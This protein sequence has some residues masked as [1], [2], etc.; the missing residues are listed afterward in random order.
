MENSYRVLLVGGEYS[1][2]GAVIDSLRQEGT[3]ILALGW[4][5]PAEV[6]RQASDGPN[7]VIVD[8]AQD[9]LRGLETISACR[10]QA[11]EA[12]LVVVA[13]DLSVE[14]ERTVRAS[15]V[16]YL[17]VH[18]IAL[19]EIR[20]ILANAFECL[21]RR[22]PSASVVKTPQKVLV[23]DDDP[24]FTAA[25]TALLEAEGYVVVTAASGS[26]GLAKVA[27][28]RPSLVILDIMMEDQWAGYA[29]NQALKF[30][31]GLEWARCVPI[32]MVSSVPVD[33]ATRFASAP[34]ALMVTPDA[35]LTKPVDAAQLL[36]KVRELCRK[37]AG[38]S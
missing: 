23:V 4:P 15:G 24:D 33:P 7:V 25:V 14:L 29:V 20:N 1:V 30:G 5:D 6:A 9:L 2:W 36:A 16:F 13:K 27:S 38:T 34:E 3:E 31:E 22:K 18:P 37:P 8:L 21:G 17:T 26:E 10:R 35:Y 32:L 28:E 12:P 11:R 19:D